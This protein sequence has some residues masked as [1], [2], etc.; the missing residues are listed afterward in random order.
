MFGWVSFL[1]VVATTLIVVHEPY[2]RIFV[3]RLSYLMEPCCQNFSYNFHFLTHFKFYFTLFFILM[4]TDFPKV[5]E[6]ILFENRL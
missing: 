6:L 4:R 3:K 1:G 2:G 5:D